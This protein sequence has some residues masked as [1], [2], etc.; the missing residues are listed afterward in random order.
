MWQTG[1]GGVLV[2]FGPWFALV[3]RAG[4]TPADHPSR[5]DNGPWT[6]SFSPSRHVS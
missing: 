3:V 6:S 4:Y 1:L 2:G 5:G